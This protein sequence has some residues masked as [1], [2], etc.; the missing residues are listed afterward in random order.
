[1]AAGEATSAFTLG[2]VSPP[3][4]QGEGYQGGINEPGS[5]VIAEA[6]DHLVSAIPGGPIAREQQHKFVTN[7]VSKRINPHSASGNVGNEA[8][9]RWNARSRLDFR[10]HSRG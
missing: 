8:I 9:A 2:S 7:G 10:Q 3:N 5:Y 6:L 4:F 1:M